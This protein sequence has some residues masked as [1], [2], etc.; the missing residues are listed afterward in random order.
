[1]KQIHFR[2]S[3]WIYVLL[4]ILIATVFWLYVRRTQDPAQ[5]GVIRNIPVTLIGER[6]LEG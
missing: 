1:M 6:V 5:D 3:K 2:D 4:S